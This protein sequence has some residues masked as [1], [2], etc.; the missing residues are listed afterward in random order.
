MSFEK[1]AVRE[2]NTERTS[3]AELATRRDL[4]AAYRLVAMRGWDDVIY[5]HISA[6]A[7]DEPNQFLITSGL[8]DVAD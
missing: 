4:A 8:A 1:N 6:A 5:T 2:T 3:A 7:P